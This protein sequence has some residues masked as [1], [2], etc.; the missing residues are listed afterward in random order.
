M[1]ST[2]LACHKIAVDAARTRRRRAQSSR[3]RQTAR[4]RRPL[5]AGSGRR[6]RSTR[7]AGLQ[8]ALG[9]T[10]G[11][12]RELLC[13]AM[14]LPHAA[15]GQPL[16]VG[17]QAASGR[18]LPPT[19]CSLRSGCAVDE[20]YGASMHTSTLR[21]RGRASKLTWV[22]LGVG[23]HS[24]TVPPSSARAPCRGPPAWRRCCNLVDLQPLSCSNALADP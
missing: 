11:R 16:K 18:F 12:R 2:P 22:S 24:A 4:R 6:P 5:R 3:S 10:I 23:K 14:L 1:E 21:G 15:A 17:A 9:G 20:R 7:L 19:G 8:L 13:A